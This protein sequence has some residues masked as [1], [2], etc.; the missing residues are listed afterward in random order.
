MQRYTVSSVERH[1]KHI[2]INLQPA[3]QAQRLHFFPGQYATISF[4]RGNK[5]SPARCFSMTSSPDDTGLQFASRIDGK[6][7]QQLSRLQRGTEVKVQGPFGRFVIDPGFDHRI[8]MLAAGIGITPFISML[9][10]ATETGLDNPIT[11]LYACRSSADIPFYDEIM[12]LARRNPHLKVY[13]L[14]SE[15]PSEKSKNV[16]KRRIDDVLLARITN[17]EFGKFSFFICGPK[18]FTGNMEHLLEDHGTEKDRLV[19]ESFSQATNLG[20]G[21]NISIPSLTY[22]TTALALLAGIGF[23]TYLDLSRY[24]PKA[25]AKAPSATTSNTPSSVSSDG[26]NSDSSSSDSFYSNSSQAAGGNTGSPASTY[27]QSYQTPM[28]TVS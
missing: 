28:S 10:H 14:V 2:A 13:F 26:G 9:R 27:S 17:G 1:G 23:F 19:T 12:V 8:V 22:V 11:L 15:G 25:E 7:T 5:W 3:V 16:F 21:V 24:L 18:A 4:K 20:L 6:F